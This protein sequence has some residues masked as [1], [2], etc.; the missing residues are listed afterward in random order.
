MIDYVVSAISEGTRNREQGTGKDKIFVVGLE[1][2]DESELNLS[3]VAYCLSPGGAD[4]VD[5]L[6]KGIAALPA[7]SDRVLVVTADVPF[8]TAEAVRDFLG[9]ATAYSEAE[10]LYS[11]V[12]AVVCRTKFPGMKRTT[13]RVAE[14]EFT[15]GNLVIL[16]PSFLRRNE[17]VIRAAWGRRK[18]VTGLAKMLGAETIL[19]LA[20]SRLAP[21]VLPIAYLEKAVGRALGGVSARL[22]VSPYPEI[23]ADCDRAEDME[24][25]ERILKG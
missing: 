14:G 25:A 5:T 4:M 17:A 10:F 18:S 6:L 7:D 19:R 8:L 3:P 15:G 16:A 13:L 1:K 22:I 23:A 24:Y 12:P 9:R 2:A 11:A 20:F 21:S